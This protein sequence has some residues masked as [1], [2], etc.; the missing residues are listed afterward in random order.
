MGNPLNCVN[1]IDYKKILECGLSS[2]N[3]FVEKL[4]E[5]NK[6][7]YCI[8]STVN[9]YDY[10]FWKEDPQGNITLLLEIDKKSHVFRYIT[11]SITRIGQI[12]CNSTIKDTSLIYYL[13]TIIINS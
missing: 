7:I 4:M 10:I 1:Y 11:G 2:N 3:L 5:K 13:N 8:F 12:M 9:Y 6:P